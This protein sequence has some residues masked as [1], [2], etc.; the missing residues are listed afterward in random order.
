VIEGTQGELLIVA[1]EHECGLMTSQP[2]ARFAPR[3]GWS[4][5]LRIV[6]A[7]HTFSL[8]TSQLTPRSSSTKS[9]KWSESKASPRCME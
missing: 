8:R 2:L 9:V 3:G 7:A 1:F 6:L 5:G 4:R